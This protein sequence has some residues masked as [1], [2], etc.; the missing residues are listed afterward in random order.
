M[1]NHSNQKNHEET[2]HYK[3]LILMGLIHLPIMYF[4]MFVMVYSANE[5]YHNLNTFYMALMMA[6]PMIIFMPLMMNKMYPDKKKNSVIYSACILIFVGSFFIIRN[7]TTIGDLQF[8]RSMIPHHSGA[9]LM[10]EKAKLEDPE[11]KALCNE[12]IIGQQ[13]EI[14]QMK[15]I[16]SRY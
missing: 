10:C 15:K 6:A 9:I 12:I 11:I 4:V 14:E 16:L 3:H 13:R 2:H 5:I 7:Q 8:L 1:H